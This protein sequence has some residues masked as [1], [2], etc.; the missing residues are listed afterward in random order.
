MDDQ[1]LRY[2]SNRQYSTEKKN[3][4][5]STRKD[6]QPASPEKNQNFNYNDHQR[7]YSKQR[8]KSPQ[9][10]I[11]QIEREIEMIQK[12][13][14]VADIENHIQEKVNFVKN[15][16]NFQKIDNTVITKFDQSIESKPKNCVD[17]SK[18]IDNIREQ[19]N[20]VNSC[21]IPLVLEKKEEKLVQ[22]EF[23]MMKKPVLPPV[24]KHSDYNPQKSN[25]W[26][27]NMSNRRTNNSIEYFSNENNDLELSDQL[28]RES[29]NNFQKENNQVQSISP[30]VQTLKNALKNQNS[31]LN[32]KEL[33]QISSILE[34][35]QFQ[36]SEQSVN[37]Q[38]IEDDL[39]YS[40]KSTVVKSQNFNT[41]ESQGPY[42]NSTQSKGNTKFGAT[43]QVHQ[44]PIE[45]NKLMALQN[46]T[47]TFSS[48]QDNRVYIENSKDIRKKL[49]LE[50]LTLERQT[51]G[52]NNGLTNNEL[53]FE[54]EKFD[55]SPERTGYSSKVNKDQFSSTDRSCK[56]IIR[57]S[58]KDLE[59]QN[60]RE[61]FYESSPN[62]ANMEREL[63]DKIKFDKVRRTQNLNGDY[64]IMM[65]MT[66]NEQ[67][68]DITENQNLSNMI[69]LGL[70]DIQQTAELYFNNEQQNLNYII[71]QQQ[72]ANTSQKEYLGRKN[73]NMVYEEF[74]GQH[75]DLNPSLATLLSSLTTGKQDLGQGFD[76]NESEVK[77]ITKIEKLSH[78]GVYRDS[79]KQ[80]QKE[81]F[82]Y[83][84]FTSQLKPNIKNMF[85][86]G[87]TVKQFLNLYF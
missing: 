42:R 50:P 84:F 48:V 82:L 49:S 18:L 11:Y 10:P 40:N 33:S 38:N 14:E 52:R 47:D 44:Y 19:F 36:S 34:K 43:Q 2:V 6:H 62:H 64:N 59:P 29:H 54:Q 74:K 55:V 37:F 69:G 32:S 86:S 26:D 12:K 16:G 41:N 85:K 4:E 30:L 24:L 27:K 67:N 56:Q 60:R 65:N 15:I 31:N 20:D 72:S 3:S 81:C 63:E 5:L 76:R 46:N 73:E 70:S 22:E 28:N 8:D 78:D 66:H 75:Q 79:D 23:R 7:F 51:F 45:D 35:I 57:E 77:F 80:A 87:D 83:T 71:N 1:Y 61:H 25:T 21:T 58:I 53:K 13:M 68:V 39:E 9:S 17:E